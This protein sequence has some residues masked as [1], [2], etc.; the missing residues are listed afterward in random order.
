LSAPRRTPTFGKPENLS[1]SWS[2]HEEIAMKRTLTA[3]ALTALAVVGMGA[4]A[5]AAPPDHAAQNHVAYWEAFTLQDDTCSKVELPDGVSSFT[6]PELPS[7]QVYTLLVLK[8]GSGSDAHALVWYPDAGVAYEHPT[9]KDLS[10][11]I[12]C[13]TEE[14]S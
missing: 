4:T 12:S 9:D 6:L 14:V 3:A 5:H 13:V 11:V 8:A 1:G 10:H 7:R 2:I